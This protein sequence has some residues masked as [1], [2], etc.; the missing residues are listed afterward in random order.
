MKS[1]SKQI[2]KLNDN[3]PN[4]KAEI[5]NKKKKKVFVVNLYWWSQANFFQI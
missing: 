1:I 3:E 5:R 2:K 4:I